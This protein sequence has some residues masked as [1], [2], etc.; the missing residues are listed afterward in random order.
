[1]DLVDRIDK[2]AFLGREWLVWLW[3]KS[4]LFEGPFELPG[5]EPVEAWLETKITL[6]A[7][8]Q[9]L[10]QS[11]LKGAAPSTS[12]EARE[13]LRQGKLPTSAR[14]GLRRGELTFGFSFKSDDLSLGAVKLPTLVN[15]QTDEKFYERMH[16]LE[17]LEAMLD[18][19]WGE[20]LSLRLSDAWQREVVPAIRDWVHDRPS[21]DVDRYRGWLSEAQS[22]AGTSE[23]KAVVRSHEEGAT[24]GVPDQPASA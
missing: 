24:R 16:L 8:A 14:L 2:S 6:E 15:E 1:M 19:L 17:D 23:K 12:P 10:E 13:A 22:P 4:E 11:Q 5:F 18:A 7:V 20:F 9:E 3:F 21:A